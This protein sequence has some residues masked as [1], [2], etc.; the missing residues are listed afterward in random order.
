VPSSTLELALITALTA[1]VIGLG[2]AI[3]AR[4]R[5]ETIEDETGSDPASD[6]DVFQEAYLDGEMSAVYLVKVRAAGGGREPPP[7]PQ[8][9]EIVRDRIRAALA[10]RPIETDKDEDEVAGSAFPAPAPADPAPLK[11]PSSD[12][13]RPGSG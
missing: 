9:D 11:G 1:A 10:N 5:R 2:I 7:A 12:G 4:Y 8:A 3:I 13:P 6:L